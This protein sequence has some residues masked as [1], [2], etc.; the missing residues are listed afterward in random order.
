MKYATKKTVNE[1]E[2]LFQFV[3]PKKLSKRITYLFLE[4]L[5]K[6]PTNALPENLNKMAEDTHFLIR[7]FD[8]AQKNKKPK[9]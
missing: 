4:Y 5:S 6:T 7:F 1:L 2:T 9:K 8:K 3:P